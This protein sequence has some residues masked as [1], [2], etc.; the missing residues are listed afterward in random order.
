MHHRYAT[1]GIGGPPK[2]PEMTTKMK[3]ASKGCRLFDDIQ[4][5]VH[6]K[7]YLHHLVCFVEI[8]PGWLRLLRVYC[9]ML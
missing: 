2:T 1:H 8:V 6:P 5:C 9:G 3:N 4:K 7:V